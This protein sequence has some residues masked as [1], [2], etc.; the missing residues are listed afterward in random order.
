M[1][2]A[3]SLIAILALAAMPAGAQPAA[4][5]IP[6]SL[7]AG[8]AVDAF[9]DGTY[10]IDIQTIA[11]TLDW[12]PASGWVDGTA[13]LDFLL[14]PGQSRAVFNFTPFAASPSA[15]SRLVLDGRALS[16]QSDA[17][18][19]LVTVAGTRQPFIELQ[20]PLDPAQPHTLTI[21]YRL[22]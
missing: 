21:D 9:L 20:L 12:H 11:V 19:R 3:A 16:P 17:D 13:R 15:I 14:R 8:A 22:T 4:A 10:R 5:W 18:V 2:H 1:K 6:D 7:A